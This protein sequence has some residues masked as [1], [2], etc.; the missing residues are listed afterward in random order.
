[1][2]GA[3]HRLVGTWDDDALRA[4]G[5][6]LRER[7]D[8]VLLLRFTTANLRHDAALVAAQLRQALC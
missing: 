2:D 4:N 8:R 3:H 6:V 1:M 7:H 5:V